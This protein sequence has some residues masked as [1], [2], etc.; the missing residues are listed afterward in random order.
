MAWTLDALYR[1]T[2]GTTLTFKGGTSLS[3]AYRLIDRLSED[4]DLIYD[5]RALA[6]DLLHD[7]NPIPLTASQEKRISA[8]V[9]ARLPGW[10]TMLLFVVTWRSI[11]AI[12]G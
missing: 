12:V 1:S 5:I 11:P 3:K 4:I 8:A 7:G 9:R 2:L 6:S 10:I